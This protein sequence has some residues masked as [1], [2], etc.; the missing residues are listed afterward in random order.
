MASRLNSAGVRDVRGFSVNRPQW[1]VVR[2]AGTE[3][4][5]P[6]QAGGGR[7]VELL[8]WVK[9]PG[10]SDGECGIAPSVPAGRFSPG[11][12]VRLIDGT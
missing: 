1:T 7:W 5:G 11:L 3:A 2:P 4:G 6:A 8:L 9:T 10:V 12:A